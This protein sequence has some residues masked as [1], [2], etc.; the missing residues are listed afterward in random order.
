MYCENTGVEPAICVVDSDPAVRD[1]LL[2]LCRA[3]GYPA[4]SFSTGTAF[5]GTLGE[6]NARSVICEA[7]L[8]DGSGVW[9]WQSLRERGVDVPFALLVSRSSQ[10]REYEAM[11]INCILSKPISD[12]TPLLGFLSS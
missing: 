7:E 5:L 4:R 10:L 11:E 1:S 8:P 9:V 12:T 6:V 3:N 2:Y